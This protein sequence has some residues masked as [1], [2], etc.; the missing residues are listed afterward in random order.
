[1]ADAVRAEPATR[2]PVDG[3]PE[4]QD[5]WR[6]IEVLP[7][8]PGRTRRVSAPMVGR[9]LERELLLRLFERV[10]VERS[11]HLVSVLGPGGVGKS[12]LVDEFV[13]GLGSRAA[14]LRA[15]CPQLGDSVTV[16]PLVE[17]VRQA[18]DISS[19]DSPK[20]ARERIAH[21]LQDEERRELVTERVAQTLGVGAATELPEDTLWAVHRLLQ[22]RARRRPLVVVIDDL[23]WADSIL[24]DAVEQ[25]IDLSQDPPV[26]L[27]C[28]AHPVELL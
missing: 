6:L 27:V 10:V 14:V 3:F 9:D 20:V 26:L 25:L 21:L 23:Q 11:C 13:E 12:R 8:R 2:L 7:E 4:P 22:A 16:W 24:L 28:V 5:T 15:Q 17:I 18:A 1:V 19:D